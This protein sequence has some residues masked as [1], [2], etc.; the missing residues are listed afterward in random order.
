VLLCERD[1]A[2]GSWERPLK[3]HGKTAGATK[4]YCVLS[5]GR[6]V[7]LG[8]SA[9]YGWFRRAD[10]AFRAARGLASHL[11][12]LEPLAMRLLRGTDPQAE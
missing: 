10:H 11:R 4:H 8:R 6:R 1:H 5:P 3:Q 7:P 9:E 2:D 12:G